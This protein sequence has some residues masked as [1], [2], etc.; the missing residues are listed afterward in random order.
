MDLLGYFLTALALVPSI[1]QIRHSLRLQSIAGL[2]GAT[3]FAWVAS[4]SVWVFYGFLIGSGPVMLRNL[5][6]LLPAVVLM[7]V[8]LR[9]SSLSHAPTILLLYLAAALAMTADVRRGLLVMLCLDVY[10]Y[11]PSVLRV[12]RDRD[13]SGVSLSA[14]I[15]YIGL[16][17]S[18]LTYL[19]LTG[20]ALAGVGWAVSIV[21]YAVITFRLLS[22]RRHRAY[23]LTAVAT[24]GA[25]DRDPSSSTYSGSERWHAHA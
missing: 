17:S 21:V 7:V 9:F 15:A 16:S 19:I 13:V 10:F 20:S 6:G 11:I 18:W 4:W 22:L 2:S 1:T 14:S 12:F 8:F 23:T 3:T 24:V 5:L 25:S